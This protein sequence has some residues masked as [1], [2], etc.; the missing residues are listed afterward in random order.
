MIASWTQAGVGCYIND[1][2][3]EEKEYM[4]N[5]YG[6]VV[7]CAYNSLENTLKQYVSTPVKEDRDKFMFE[8]FKSFLD[9]LKK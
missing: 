2:V 9:D 1:V 5:E 3:T 8:T 6:I 4:V 7:E